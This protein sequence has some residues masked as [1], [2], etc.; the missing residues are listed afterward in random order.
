MRN[1]PERLQLLHV[2]LDEV[3]DIG[4]TLVAQVRSQHRVEDA[5]F[6]VD[7]RDGE[8]GGAADSYR[9]GWSDASGRVRATASRRII[10]AAITTT[11]TIRVHAVI[12]D[13][14]QF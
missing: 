8:R 4:R 3:A 9:P 6:A 10:G 13:H 11:G 1:N 14:S 5:G 12:Q 2:S 7:G